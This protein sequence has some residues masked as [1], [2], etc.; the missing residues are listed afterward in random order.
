MSVFGL[1]L[2]PLWRSLAVAP[3]PVIPRSAV[4]L[5]HLISQALK[6]FGCFFKR[7]SWHDPHSVLHQVDSGIVWESSGSWSISMEPSRQHS[8]EPFP[9]RT[10]FLP[11]IAVLIASVPRAILGA[12]E[13]KWG[14]PGRRF[15]NPTPI[16]GLAPFLAQA[17][18]ITEQ[19]CNKR[20]KPSRRMPQ[21]LRFPSLTSS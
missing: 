6:P 9:R 10:S 21:R 18:A 12:N 4:F 11:L 8:S 19:N 7:I 2:P 14:A 13:D 16:N 5:R 1:L 20:F 15:C 17:T 3:F